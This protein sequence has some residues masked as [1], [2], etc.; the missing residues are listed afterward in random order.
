MTLID[1]LNMINIVLTIKKYTINIEN[2]VPNTNICAKCM[3]QINNEF[4]PDLE[5][6][7]CKSN[8]FVNKLKDTRI[9]YVFEYIEANSDKKINYLVKT[10]AQLSADPNL[11]NKLKSVIYNCNWGSSIPNRPSGTP[12]HYLLEYNDNNDIIATVSYFDNYKINDH[13]NNNIH[14]ETQQLHMTSGELGWVCTNNKYRKKGYISYLI[15]NTLDNLNKIS[16]LWCIDNVLSTMYFGLGFEYIR[17]TQNSNGI[18]Y[19]ENNVYYMKYRPNRF[20]SPINHNNLRLTD[21][22]NGIKLYTISVALQYNSSNH[23]N[24]ACGLYAPINI[25]MVLE[26]CKTNN[27]EILNKIHN[28]EEYNSLI[29]WYKSI[30]ISN[31]ILNKNN[32]TIPFIDTEDINR[33]EF[34]FYNILN[35]EIT[36]DINMPIY[37]KVNNMSLDEMGKNMAPHG[38]DASEIDNHKRNLVFLNELKLNIDLLI[39]STISIYSPPYNS[40]YNDSKSL[41]RLVFGTGNPYIDQTIINQKFR[42][43]SNFY[44]RRNYVFGLQIAAE[45]HWISS[46]INKVNNKHEIYFMDSMGREINYYGGLS[47]MLFKLTKFK[48]LGKFMDK[49]LQQSKLYIIEQYKSSI[50]DIITNK[51]NTP[52]TAHQLQQTV[53]MH[54]KNIAVHYKFILTNYK[55]IYSN[56]LHEFALWFANNSYISDHRK[57]EILNNYENIKKTMINTLR[58]YNITSETILKMKIA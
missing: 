38:V 12:T 42:I 25:L 31:L 4:K 19:M 52:D 46:V 8:E 11:S 44:E 48:T 1:V 58:G 39:N 51:Y 16:W 43:L 30:T 20:L 41:I 23:H 18:Q 28:N 7:K 10:N 53:Q 5:C 3:Q 33:Y 57:N 49:L 32:Q 15:N 27:D 40:N 14:A 50:N 55:W 6:K 45:G 54:A 13:I 37:M 24:K 29:D 17:N 36:N 21:N 34:N 35:G 2:N 47:D 22:K 56:K 26:A 9:E